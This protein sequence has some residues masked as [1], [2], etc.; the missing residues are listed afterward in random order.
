MKSL[1]DHITLVKKQIRHDNSVLK[2]LQ[3]N[4]R[5]CVEC[6][7]RINDFT[8]LLE[9]LE[10]QLQSQTS[11]AKTSRAPRLTLLPSDIE[12]LPQEVRAQLAISA[13]DIADFNIISIIEDLGGIASLDQIIIA[14]Y[15]KTG[16]VMERSK[17]TAKIY[18][19]VQKGLLKTVEGKK[20]VY[21]LSDYEE[22]D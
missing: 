18:R 16:V 8:S 21:A 17:A 3:R 22:N 6:T 20:A 12:D 7:K 14:E 13:S 15:R 4:S 9:F 2:K 5:G 1:T 19:I 11:S 10:K